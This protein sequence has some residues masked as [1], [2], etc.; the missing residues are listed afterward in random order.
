MR[1]IF[2]TS[3]RGYSMVPTIC[4]RCRCVQC[5]EGERVVTYQYADDFLPEFSLG[6]LGFF[7]AF[8][9]CSPSI[10]TEEMD[11]FALMTYE[12]NV[13]AKIWKRGR[14]KK[15]TKARVT[16]QN[17]FLIFMMNIIKQLWTEAVY[18]NVLHSCEFF[19]TCLKEVPK[20][21]P[22]ETIC[23]ILHCL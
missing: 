5:A 4:N 1:V 23:N 15:C 17:F 21:L 20:L 13:T 2:I 16:V 8:C 7:Y 14:R 22:P 18:A 6:N 19:F 9:T 12:R 10:Y 3:T 11:F